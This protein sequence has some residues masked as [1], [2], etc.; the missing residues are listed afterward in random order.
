[1]VTHDRRPGTYVAPEIA[2]DR[3]L[4]E[5]VRLLQ[6]ISQLRGALEAA[7]RDNVD[8]CRRP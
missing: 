7:R 4:E 2:Y 6:R 3:L 5:N 1:M 8:R